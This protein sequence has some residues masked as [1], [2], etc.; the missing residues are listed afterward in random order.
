MC[1]YLHVEEHHFDILGRVE[2]RERQGHVP[3]AAA[4]LHHFNG[5]KRQRE[6][7]ECPRR[8]AHSSGGGVGGGVGAAQRKLVVNQGARGGQEVCHLSAAHTP[9]H[10]A[11][12]SAIFLLQFAAQVAVAAVQVH[13]MRNVCVS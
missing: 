13:D 9:T 5:R 12:A 4:K 2:R 3:R 11:I 7:Q 10:L 1:T 6:Q 8:A